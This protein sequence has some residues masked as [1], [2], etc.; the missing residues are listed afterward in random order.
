MSLVWPGK[1][2]MVR[3]DAMPIAE[4]ADED[5]L[6]AALAVAVRAEGGQG[7]ALAFQISAGDVVEQ[8]GR[9]RRW[10]RITLLEPEHGNSRWHSW[11]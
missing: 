6:F 9:A 3:G 7:V 11:S 2:S 4:Q 5:W 1:A 10:I 8:Q